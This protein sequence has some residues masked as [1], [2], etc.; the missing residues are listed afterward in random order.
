M[1]NHPLFVDL[2]VVPH[3]GWFSMS[4]LPRLHHHDIITIVGLFTH[5]QYVIYIYIYVTFVGR[6]MLVHNSLLPRLSTHQA[7]PCTFTQPVAA[8]YMWAV[9]R[10]RWAKVQL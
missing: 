5:R 7:N 2:R 3:V 6:I 4:P 10:I 9:Q 8:N 1:E